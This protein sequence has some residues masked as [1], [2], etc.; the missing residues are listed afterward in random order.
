VT[1]WTRQALWLGASVAGPVLLTVMLIPLRAH[2]QS[3][4][5]AIVLLV[6]VAG[7]L[8][9]QN[10]PLRLLAAVSA[11][12]SFDFLITPPLY[13]FE[14]SSAQNVETDLTLAFAVPLLGAAMGRLYGREAA[15]ERT[16]RQQVEALNVELRASRRRIVTVGDDMRQQIE[17]NLHDGVQQSLVTLSLMLTVVKDDAP[18]SLR[19]ELDEVSAGL[20]AALDELRDV[21]RGLHPSIL[22]EAGLAAALRALARR[23]ALPVHVEVHG[24][25]FPVALETTAYYVAAEAYSNAAKHGSPSKVAIS[26][27]A[28]LDGTLTLT[29]TDDG[30][31]GADASRGSGIT[32]MRD[33]AEAMGG[34][35]TVDSP[36]GQGTTVILTLPSA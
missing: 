9:R 3:V 2:V 7:G 27:T 13:H 15:R 33:R 20:L 21:A 4:V 11:A 25:R 16:L 35:L 28:G 8:A 30:A 12:L 34:S 18:D 36:P 1:H 14:V 22:V 32:G 31:G 5:I 19:P 17:R 26:V 29:V 6:V 23:S 24:D 10:W